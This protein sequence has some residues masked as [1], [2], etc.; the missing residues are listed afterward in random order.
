VAVLETSGWGNEAGKGSPGDVLNSFGLR[1]KPA[2]KGPGSRVAGLQLLH[3][4]MAINKATGLPG[5]IIFRRCR[6]LI[7]ELPALTFDRAHPEDVNSEC[8]DHAYDTCRY[9]LGRRRSKAA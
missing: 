7:R 8:S 3:E 2:A 1:F 6:N 4:P 5:L 9:L